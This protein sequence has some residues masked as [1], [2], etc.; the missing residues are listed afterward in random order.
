MLE[1]EEETKTKIV[2][3]LI[4]PLSNV[5]VYT[6]R[7]VAEAQLALDR[8]SIATQILIENDE[9]LKNFDLR[10]TWYHMPEVNLELKMSLSVELQEEE[11]RNGKAWRKILYSAPLNASYQRSFDFNVTGTSTIKAKIVSLP[12]PQELRPTE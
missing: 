12:P 3:V 5:L 4:E 1:K 10:A 2:K 7:A 9:V 6:A 8:N 11:T